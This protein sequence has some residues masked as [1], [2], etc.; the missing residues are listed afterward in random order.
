MVREANRVAMTPPEEELLTVRQVTAILNVSPGT[1]RRWADQGYL[2]CVRVGPRRDRRFRRG[3]IEVIMGKFG[4]W[5]DTVASVENLTDR[6][7][8]VLRSLLRGRTNPETAIET[9]LTLTS[10]Q[11]TVVALRFKLKARSKTELRGRLG[12]RRLLE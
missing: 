4:I 2:T 1:A 5:T 12:L 8:R 11:G 10:V 6:Q 7:R 9:G 3:D